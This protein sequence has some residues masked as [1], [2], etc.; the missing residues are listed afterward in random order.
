MEGYDPRTPWKK[1]EDKERER[2]RQLETRLGVFHVKSTGHGTFPAPTPN[3]HFGGIPV[4]F[5]DIIHPNTIPDEHN[6]PQ[7]I[8]MRFFPT[9]PM[10]IQPVSIG[11]I[12][13]HYH[14][15][16]KIA[17]PEYVVAPTLRFRNVKEATEQKLKLV[18]NI[19]KI[20]AANPVKTILIIF[21]R[22]V[23]VADSTIM[24]Y[25]TTHIKPLLESPTGMEVTTEAS[26]SAAAVD[27]RTFDEMIAEAMAA[28]AASLSAAAPK[29]AGGGGGPPTKKSR[30]TRRRHRR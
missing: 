27:E 30:K 3:A 2:H 24:K 1:I 6:W 21:Y 22:P 5:E 14:K 29:A 11:L 12:D 9:A 28:E 18:Q 25:A 7:A 23:D 8:Y 16:P 19:A 13:K 10:L 4:F 17:K 26:T 15:L 20:C